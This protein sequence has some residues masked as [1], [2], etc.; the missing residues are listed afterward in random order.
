MNFR[1]LRADEIDVRIGTV[2]KK[3]TTLLLYKDARVDMDLLDETVGP[4]NWGREHNLVGENLHCCISIWDDEKKCWVRKSDVGTES[5]TA[6]EK[7]EASDSFKRAG[8]NWGI[9]RELYT[10]KNL[11]V[12]NELIE[13]YDSNKTY[14]TFHVL[15]IEYDEHRNIIALVILNQDD[16]ILYAKGSSKKT[17]EQKEQERRSEKISAEAE[18][19]KLL[20]PLR[21]KYIKDAR[22]LKGNDAF[23]AQAYFQKCHTKS[24]YEATE[25][26]LKKAIAFVEKKIAALDPTQEEKK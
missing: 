11:R 6:S 25:D 21:D 17:A 22:M 3:T 7:G 19:E 9:G 2:G 12:K 10:A 24:M 8:V 26:E 18:A 13:W 1:T 15:E 14:D 4:M 20:K 5:K 23:D 16:K